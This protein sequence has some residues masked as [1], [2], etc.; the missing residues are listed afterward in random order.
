VSCDLIKRGA[1]WLS[2]LERWGLGACLADDMG[3]GKTI[4]FIA[5]LLHPAGG[6][7]TADAASLSDFSVRELGA[8]SQEIWPDA[9]SLDAPR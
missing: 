4:E 2:F 6:T 3:L 1:S 8:R 5:F 7:R 9:E